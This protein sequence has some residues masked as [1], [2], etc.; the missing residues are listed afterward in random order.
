MGDFALSGLTRLGW[1]L[2]KR[3]VARVFGSP[4]IDDV[5]AAYHEAGHAVFAV[6]SDWIELVGPVALAER[7]HGEAPVKLHEAAIK[8]A[9]AQGV[10]DVAEPREELIRCFLAGAAAERRIVELRGLAITPE[11]TL[12]AAGGDYAAVQTQ[13]DK[14]SFDRPFQ[15]LAGYEADATRFMSSVGWA[16]VERFAEELLERRSMSGTE[17]VALIEQLREEL[18]QAVGSDD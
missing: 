15:T 12:V 17:A 6:A 8:S 10:L 11:A 18:D 13:M 1:I 3:L 7:G 5:V 4:S 16:V 9:L 2:W 14:L